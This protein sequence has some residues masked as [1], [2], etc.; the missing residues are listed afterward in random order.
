MKKVIIALIMLLFSFANAKD[1]TYFCSTNSPTK[2]F[3]G[4]FA[5][6]SGLN[7]LSRNIIESQVARA[8]KKETGSKF[9]IKINNFY[10]NNI[11]G[12]EFKN[13]KATSKKYDDGTIFLSNID[14]STICT[15][16]QISYKDEKVYFLEPMVLKFSAKITQDDLNQM[17]K[18]SSYQKMLDKM[19]QDSTISSLIKIQSAD[20][21]IKNDKLYF[22]YVVSPLPR[23]DLGF[24]SK[25]LNKKIDVIFSAGLKVVDGE[26]EICDFVLNS[27]TK[28]YQTFMPI[29]NKLNPTSWKMD[30]DE[31]NQGKLEIDKVEIANDEIL[32]N[33]YILIEKNI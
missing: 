33:G 7:T 26:V 23:F 31:N 18:S 27:K 5:S 15:Y 3:T 32:L 6:L 4:T 19:N 30:I 11:L 14:V 10:G 12:G 8:I 20:V 21:V 17:I 25:K 29:I 22:K 16:N 24:I 9:K 28:N 13:L 1:Y 2:S